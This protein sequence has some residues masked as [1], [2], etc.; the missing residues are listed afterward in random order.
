MVWGGLHGLGLAVHKLFLDYRGRPSGTPHPLWKGLSWLLTLLF[1]CVAW[2]FFRAP[3]FPLAFGMLERMF[4]LTDSAGIQ[5]FQTSTLVALPL[6][7]AC[8][9]LGSR[10]QGGFRLR[11]TT[12]SGLFVFFFVLLAL[13]FLAPTQASPFIYFQF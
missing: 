4:L 11:L 13:L 1:V 8:H 7:I 10:Y 2:V 12:F 6:V 5:W 3:D 9:Y